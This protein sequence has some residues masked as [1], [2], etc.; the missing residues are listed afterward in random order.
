MLSWRTAQKLIIVAD[1]NRSSVSGIHAVGHPEQES[2][3][4]M[5]EG[6]AEFHPLVLSLCTLIRHNDDLSVN[7]RLTNAAIQQDHRSL[8]NGFCNIRVNR[9]YEA[10]EFTI[11]NSPS[12]INAF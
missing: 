11:P 9:M 12:I 3:F 8:V 6:D 5:A 4:V 7:K 1:I 10:L 2:L